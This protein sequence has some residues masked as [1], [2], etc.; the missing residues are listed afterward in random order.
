MNRYYILDAK[1]NAVEVQRPIWATWI[2]SRDEPRKRLVAVSTLSH[3]I[4]M[5]VF[6]GLDKGNNTPPMIYKTEVFFTGD[7]DTTYRYPAWR[8]WELGFWNRRCAKRIA[9]PGWYLAWIGHW[10]TVFKLLWEY[11]FH[12]K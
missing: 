10:V 1:H 7:K 4:V 3:A 12:G 2:L 9:L 8:I 11:T 6:D 5:T